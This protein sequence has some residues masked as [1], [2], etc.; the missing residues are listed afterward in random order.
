MKTIHR[1]N[2]SLL[3]PNTTSHGQDLRIKRAKKNGAPI[4]VA[5][6]GSLNIIIGLIL[7][8]CGLLNKPN[9]R[10][11]LMI[12][13]CWAVA[14]IILALAIIIF[15]LAIAHSFLDG[16]RV[17]MIYG[18]GILLEILCIW[19]VASYFK[20]LGIV[21]HGPAQGY[22]VVFNSR[23]AEPQ[24]MHQERPSITSEPPSYATS[25]HSITSLEIIDTT[26]GNADTK[27][28]V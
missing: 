6:V 21:A 10:M 28:T 14:I 11:L 17:F 3:S 25:V 18:I 20:Y 19:V 27:A 16:L 26:N 5:L 15:Y 24:Q 4:T 8:M 2:H 9:F 13:I 1:S 7:F 22:R 12:W 23:G